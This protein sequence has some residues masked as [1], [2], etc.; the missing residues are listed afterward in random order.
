MKLFV[1]EDVLSD[2]TS[3]I[4]FALA[5][6]ESEARA[7]INEKVGYRRED[8]TIDDSE[9]RHWDKPKIYTTKIAYALYGGG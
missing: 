3:G 4:A 7:L 6:T 2:Y 9:T 1:W 8:G 5:R